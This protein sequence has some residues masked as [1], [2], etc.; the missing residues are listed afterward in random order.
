[1]A[2]DAFGQLQAEIRQRLEQQRGGDELLARMDRREAIGQAAWATRPLATFVL[3]GS[4]V[5]GFGIMELGDATS[6]P[7][8]LIEYGANAPALVAEGQWFRLF[9]ANFLHANA[10]HLYMNGLGLWAL[11]SL[12]ERLM[13]PWRLTSVYLLSALGGSLASTLAAQAAFSVGASTAIFGL[14]GAMA[15]VNWRFGSELP[16]GFRQP[17]RWWIFILGVNGAL[18]L[19]V[20]Q[21]DVAAHVGGFASGALATLLLCARPEAIQPRRPTPRLIQLLACALTL[22]FG[23]ALAQAVGHGL[24]D[25]PEDRAVVERALASDRESDPAGLN[26]IAWQYATSEQASPEE[27]ELA[28]VAAERAAAL[29]PGEIEI[30]DTLAT[31]YHRLGDWDRAIQLERQVLQQDDRAFFQSQVARFLEA[32]LI[33]RGPLELGPA[34]HAER[35]ELGP[36]PGGADA[37]EL[38]LRADSAYPEG[39]VLWVLA[40]RNGE[41]EGAFIIRLGQSTGPLTHRFVPEDAPRL[42]GLRLELALVDATGCDACASG[43]ARAQFVRMDPAALELP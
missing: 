38:Q 35:L 29:A 24:G 26:A 13:G 9:S 42:E 5:L 34:A 37:S 20:P 33:Q 41:L 2:Q 36:A 14:L 39:A 12:L 30:T 22:V 31:V 10:L 15:V 19:L 21:I 16:G 3:L 40:Q 6:T 28:R 23:V 17:R 18:P 4:V 7:L 32:R 25:H 11:G 27:L 1:M 8:G 43:S